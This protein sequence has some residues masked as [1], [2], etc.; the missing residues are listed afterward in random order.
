[1]PGVRFVIKKVI[2]FNSWPVCCQVH[3]TTLRMTTNREISGNFTA[4]MEMSGILVKIREMSGKNYCEGKL[5]KNFLQNCI[6]RIFCITHFNILSVILHC[7][8][9]NVAY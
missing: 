3:V 7:L 6:R 8:L 1:M 9:L 2:S 4:V 5:P